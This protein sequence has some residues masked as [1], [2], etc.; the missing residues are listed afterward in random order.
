MRSGKWFWVARDGCA[1]EVCVYARKPTW[2]P[3]L[4]WWIGDDD[5]IDALCASGFYRYTGIRVD[6]GECKRVR[7]TP[8]VK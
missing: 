2:H 3:T 8:E 6:E 4:I 7:L 1:S 5:P